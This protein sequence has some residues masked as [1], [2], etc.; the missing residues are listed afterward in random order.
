MASDAAPWDEE[1]Y[2]LA[3]GAY[4]DHSHQQVDDVAQDPNVSGDAAENGTD[5]GGDYDPE[6]VSFDTSALVPD[7]APAAAPSQPPASKPKMSGGFIMEA[8]DE[9]DDAEE[10]GEEEESKVAEEAP[11]PV[12]GQAAAP[13]PGGSAPPQNPGDR[14]ERAS[15]SVSVAPTP[16][17]VP[18]PQMMTPAGLDPTAL[19]EARIKEDPRGDMDAWLNL[20]AD[21]RRRSNMDALRGVYNRFLEVFP[22]AVSH[23]VSPIAG[24]PELTR[25]KGG[26]VGGMDRDGAG[27]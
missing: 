4:N 21:H 25:L 11:A 14:S 27:S 18:A 23:A 10:E 12:L 8:S 19:L 1:G 2:G 15:R 6:S 5:D 3:D 24:W 22:Q 9:E 7:P 17:G 26:Y 13:Q 16:A 20:M